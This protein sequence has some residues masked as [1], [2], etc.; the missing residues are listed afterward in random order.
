MVLLN[1]KSFH[2]KIKETSMQYLILAAKGYGTNILCIYM[3]PKWHSYTSSPT[4][5]KH[6]QQ[7]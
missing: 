3:Q 2:L 6:L 1:S 5:V 4:A 7:L